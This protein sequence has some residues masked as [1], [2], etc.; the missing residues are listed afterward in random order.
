MVRLAF[1]WEDDAKLAVRFIYESA[2]AACEVPGEICGRSKNDAV[3]LSQLHSGLLLSQCDRLHGHN[4]EESYTSAGNKVSGQLS[5]SRDSKGLRNALPHL[6]AASPFPS[7]EVERTKQVLREEIQTGKKLRCGVTPEVLRVSVLGL[8]TP[9]ERQSVQPTRLLYSA[10]KARLVRLKRHNIRIVRAET[11]G[12]T[13]VSR[14]SDTV[15]SFCG[16]R[17]EKFEDEPRVEFYADNFAVSLMY[18]A[19]ENCLSFPRRNSASEARATSRQLSNVREEDEEC[20]TGAANRSLVSQKKTQAQHQAGKIACSRSGVF[21][22]HV[23]LQDYMRRGT[24]G[25]PTADSQSQAKKSQWDRRRI[26]AESTR[27]W[28]STRDP[29]GCITIRRAGSRN[30]VATNSRSSPAAKL[31][32]KSSSRSSIYEQRRSRLRNSRNALPAAGVG[33]WTN[34][35]WS[36]EKPSQLNGRRRQVVGHGIDWARTRLYQDVESGAVFL[37]NIQENT[38]TELDIEASL[39]SMEKRSGIAVSDAQ[40]EKATATCRKL[41]CDVLCRTVDL[42]AAVILSQHR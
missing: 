16:E 21:L 3:I 4:E 29:E 23:T 34:K 36:A 26:R 22:G 2:D 38:L 8:S 19:S 24:V 37:D 18:S 5:D 32:E 33:F 10:S 17:S 20:P 41:A 40:F 35:T 27:R 13:R 31:L 7:I 42:P 28:V 25:L 12:R 9:T 14:G 39:S 15:E 1:E 30:V 6:A 11:A